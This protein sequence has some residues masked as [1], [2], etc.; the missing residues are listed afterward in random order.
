MRVRVRVRG[1]VCVVRK[2][3]LSGVPGAT[4]VN[5]EKDVATTEQNTPE[6]VYRMV[7]GEQDVN[8]GAEEKTKE[9]WD[10]GSLAKS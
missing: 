1:R 5:E 10:F 7:R 9:I 3:P 8:S 6:D 4:A 2:R